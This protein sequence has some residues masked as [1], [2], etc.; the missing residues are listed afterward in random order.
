MATTRIEL[1]DSVRR[2]VGQPAK[3]TD[4]VL[5]EWINEAIR[6]YSAHFRSP[7]EVNVITQ[8]GV[9]EYPIINYQVI[10][11]LRIEFPWGLEP[12]RFLFRKDRSAP[13]FLD[14]PHYDFYF[15]AMTFITIVLAEKPKAG[16][17]FGLLCERAHSLPAIDS[18]PLTVPDHHVEVLR[19][20]CVWRCYQQ[21]VLEASQS[22]DPYDSY[23]PQLA[24][25]E[26][27]AGRA[28]KAYR[29]KMVELRPRGS[30]GGPVGS[31]TDSRRIY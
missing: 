28:E 19:L 2:I 12:K 4:A 1:R 5:N 26:Q 11:V 21:L 9:R 6:D 23:H 10:E 3:W 31:W 16:E 14:G 22:R 24:N 15:H 7:Y 29:S 18:T 25:L 17:V 27:S 20:F 13:D 8:V 30:P